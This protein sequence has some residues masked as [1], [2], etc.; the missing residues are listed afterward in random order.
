MPARAMALPGIDADAC[1]LGR[2]AVADCSL[3]ADACPRGALHRIEAGLGLD[4]AACSGCGAC[5]ASCPQQAIALDGAER[6]QVAGRVT[7]G[8]AALVCP[9]RK[10]QTGDRL[11]LQALGIES[12][13]RLWLAGVRGI[14]A[15][16]GD[17]GQC[18]DGTTLAVADRLAALNAVLRDRGLPAMAVHR[19]ATAPRAM[20]RIVPDAPGRPDPARRSFLGLGATPAPDRRAGSS[21][22]RLQ[23]L[24]GAATL[25]PRFVFAPRID[26]DRCTG[27][28]ACLRLCP[29][30]ALSLI[31]ADGG[32]LVYDA[33]S[34]QCSGCGLCV[35]LCS[36]NAM[37]IETL[38]S[39]APAL[40]LAELR[41][42]D[43]GLTVHVPA[44][45]PWAGAELCPVCTKNGHRH[46]LFQVLP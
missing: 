40:P 33:H 5:A 20:A 42:R 12:L 35:D 39:S 17:C 28:D 37:A 11:C 30:G 29:T 22:A 23:S 32:E 25:T 8:Q 34:S 41:C 46:R 18:P 38:A 10:D 16:C 13:A 4:P 3:C 43:C 7:Q 14:V 9:A 21:L 1:S 44:K 2:L 19:A 36:A 31:K 45:G 27:C 15:V 6:V 26:P 24:P